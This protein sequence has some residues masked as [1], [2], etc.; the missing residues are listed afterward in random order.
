MK[1]TPIICPQCNAQIKIDAD[2]ELVSAN[3]VGQNLS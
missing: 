2:K 3:I 1:I